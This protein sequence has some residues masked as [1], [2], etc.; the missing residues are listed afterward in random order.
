MQDVSLQLNQVSPLKKG[1]QAQ[2]GF[3]ASERNDAAAPNGFAAL[4]KKQVNQQPAKAEPAPNANAQTQ[5]N[6]AASA[7][8]QAANTQSKQAQA[9]N[10]QAKQAQAAKENAAKPSS[11]KESTRAE[12]SDADTTTRDEPNIQNQGIQDQGIQEIVLLQIGLQAP[13]IAP[14]TSN[15]VSAE[16]L[17]NTATAASETPDIT[18][19]SADLT[20]V[21]EEA[22]GKEPA[23][24]N[25]QRPVNPQVAG[26]LNVAQQAVARN[27]AN[28]QEVLARVQA[29]AEL[30]T[31]NSVARPEFNMQA[32]PMANQAAQAVASTHQVATA[33]GKADWN[34]AIHQRVVYMLGAG[35]QSA[36][37]TLN[38]PNLGPLQVVIKVDNDHVDT[39]FIS[40]NADVRQAL[41]DGLGM[42]KDKLNE[43][44]MQLNNANVSSQE[45]SQRD[46]QQLAQERGQQRGQQNGQ[47]T[48]DEEV[49][50]STAQ[51]KVVSNGLV[52]TF[53]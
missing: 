35:E 9:A 22:I 45:Q 1:T 13:V 27:D 20:P 34:Q 14:P 43:S 42:L 41:Q 25:H 15:T 11:S 37:L 5:A 33:F 12:L 49:S 18:A 29:N 53:A 38:P 32:Q 44:G 50:V 24:A 46:F 52:D 30:T 47:S 21:T 39:T 8:T 17:S 31:A 16:P 40:N 48:A 51:T 23:Q 36:T 28:S 7:R 19:L 6:Q 10:A 3:Q 2:S 4:F 26:G